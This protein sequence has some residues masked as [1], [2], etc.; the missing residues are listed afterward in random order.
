MQK[1][2]G[3]YLLISEI[4]R[5]EFG[6]VFL[7]T[8]KSDSNRFFAVKIIPRQPFSDN[9]Q[10]LSEVINHDSHLV[11]NCHN[12]GVLK[13]EGLLK[14]T[15]NHYL[16]MPYCDGGR[17]VDLIERRNGL[18][19]AEAL[20]LFYQLCLALAETSRLNLRVRQYS[21][22]NVL[23]KGGQIMVKALNFITL[24]FDSIQ[25]R[26]HSQAHLP[27]EKL[28][29][30][31]ILG[32]FQSGKEEAWFA[33]QMLYRMLFNKEPYQINDVQQISS[34]F[35][36]A[37]FIVER[38][39]TNLTF[40]SR[41]IT[42]SCKSLLRTLLD[43]EHNSRPTIFHVLDLPEARELKIRKSSFQHNVPLEK[44]ILEESQV[45]IQNP[46]LSRQPSKQTEEPN[47]IL[48][49]GSNNDIKANELPKYH[50]NTRS[51]ENPR[52]NSFNS[53]FSLSA[54]QFDVQKKASD[55]LH[56]T[57]LMAMVMKQ[58]R[59]LAKLL[60]CD[61]KL[62]AQL[63]YCSVMLL[64]KSILLLEKVSTF[65]ISPT[66][67]QTVQTDLE[68]QEK[69]LKHVLSNFMTE[70]ESRDMT[71]D[72]KSTT[73]KGFS[74]IAYIDF[75]LLQSLVYLKNSTRSLEVGKDWKNDIIIV[76]RHLLVCIKPAVFIPELQSDTQSI[77]WEGF[78]RKISTPNFCCKIES[79]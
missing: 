9:Y 58:L 34:D 19:E 29:S 73:T 1:E 16:V 3:E 2:V 65:D 10:L 24:G 74:V 35:D 60:I 39:G 57:K 41:G 43:P 12:S 55:I 18:P 67:K 28:S 21:P 56:L 32:Q 38:T 7:A 13:L 63:G 53:S 72:L 33:G 77:D 11:K 44:S 46:Y 25:P 31:N 50:H 27:V 61:T 54:K 59:K 48:N 17:L 75:R 71:L 15:N 20:T 79:I 62:C 37:L 6:Q 40:P 52:Q 70:F 36:L 68:L 64:K 8:L 42:D 14:T 4:G 30:T 69:Y 45:N 51:L 66:L 47:K 78:S 5:G 76:A 22:N 49:F 23:L 26:I